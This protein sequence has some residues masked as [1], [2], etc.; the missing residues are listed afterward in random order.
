[1]NLVSGHTFEGRRFVIDG[2]RF[3]DCQFTRCKLIF[4]ASDTVAFDGCTFTE[5]DWVFE[6]AALLTLQFLSAL[7]NGVGP[8][9]VA[10][11]NEVFE[12]VNEGKLGER[13]FAPQVAA[14]V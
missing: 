11:V 6:D 5:C 3:V 14:A 2:S 10:L 4:R 7:R 1:M 9:G 12:S 13:L 8:E